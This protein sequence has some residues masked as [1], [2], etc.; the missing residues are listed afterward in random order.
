MG[1]GAKGGGQGGG[2]GAGGQLGRHPSTACAAC[3]AC[4]SCSPPSQRGLSEGRRRPGG[5][6][7]EGGTEGVVR[8]SRCSGMIPCT[9]GGALPPPLLTSRAQKSQLTQTIQKSDRT[10]NK[11]DSFT[12]GIESILKLG[13]IRGQSAILQ[14]FTQGFSDPRIFTVGLPEAQR[15]E[16]FRRSNFPRAE[17]SKRP[18]PFGAPGRWRR[19]GSARSA[20]SRWRPREPLRAL[21]EADR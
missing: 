2:A 19:S 8:G 7:A 6:Q 13:L 17:R 12:F 18:Q 20:R 16:A 1:R 10:E 21:P 4:A 3:A 11:F 15:N 9:G 5:A 14:V